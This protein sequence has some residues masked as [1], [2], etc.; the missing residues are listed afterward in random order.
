MRLLLLHLSDIH[1][2]SISDRVVKLSEKIASSIYPQIRQVDKCVILITGDITN[3]G[4][5]EEFEVAADFFLN[6]KQTLEKESGKEV[7]IISVPGNHDCLLKPEN[8]VRT[9]IIEGLTESDAKNSQIVDMCTS[10]QE[11]Y[12]AFRKR[13]TLINPVFEDK[14]WSEYEVLVNGQPIRFSAI[15]AS[16][17]SSIHEK[18]G[19]LIFPIDNYSNYL[20]EPSL[21][22]FVLLHHPLNWYAQTSI[23]PLKRTL[24]YSATAVLSGHEHHGSS[25]TIIDNNYGTSLFFEAPALQP[26]E[27]N[28]AVECG[29][30]SL[31]FDFVNQ[32]VIETAF[33]IS[34]YQTVECKTTRTVSIEQI[35]TV[36]TELED[37]TQE[38]QNVL[39]DPGADFKSNNETEATIDDFYV[40]PEIQAI[41]GNDNSYLIEDSESLISEDPHSKKILFIGES[42]SGKTSLIFQAFKRYRKLGLYPIY[43]NG[44]ELKNPTENEINKV[45]TKAQT[46]QYLNPSIFSSLPKDKMVVLVDNIDRIR[47]GLRALPKL[48]EFLDKHYCAILITATTGFEFGEL[49]DKQAQESTKNFITYSIR[50]LGKW[51]KHRLIRRWCICSKTFNTSSE[52]ESKIFAVEKTLNVV[53]GKNLVPGVP[54]YILILLQSIEK[55][56]ESALTNSH[57]GS[58]Y[59]YMIDRSL[60]DAGVV[61]AKIVEI[62][63]YLSAL[64]WLFNDGDIRE[65]SIVELRAFNKQYSEIQNSVDLES[66]LNLLCK[67]RMLVKRDDY[68]SFTYP[69][70][71]YYFLGKYIA[72]NINKI[73]ELKLKVSK[74]CEAL[75]KK[76]YANCILFI[77]HHINDEWIIN[78]VS[79]ELDKCFTGVPDICFNGDIDSINELVKITSTLIIDAP[80]VEKFREEELKHSDRKELANQ[81][82]KAVEDLE[83]NNIEISLLI[84]HINKSFITSRILGQILKGYHGDISR[85]NRE[86][87]INKIFSS[88]LRFLFHFIS[89]LMQDPTALVSTIESGLEP[90]EG[91]S[92]DERIKEIRQNIY[93]FIGILCTTTLQR[94]AENVSSDDLREDISEVAKNKGT[95]AYR[96]IEAAT[97]FIR[98]NSLPYDAILK[99]S[100]D[101]AQNPFAFRLL[102]SLAAFHIRS[103]PMKDSDRQKLCST[104]KIELLT[105]RPADILTE[106]IK[107][108]II[109]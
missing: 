8:S 107:P 21:A 53:L 43:L 61:P 59:G 19:S 2:S 46:E 29:F 16:W 13:T 31:D 23:H 9:R 102:Q 97:N 48:I 94:T 35:T 70:I 15:N 4:T 104:T 18:P 100:T 49:L 87:L 14:L 91:Q 47:S 64:A 30:L 56:Q 37:I 79:E 32:K 60:R 105:S 1:L 5:A 38:F 62:T 84:E 88:Q 77:A 17:M 11:N 52:L 98:P 22:R 44:A 41:S 10:A 76:D 12:F 106:T 80:N 68:Y 40:F 96:L 99:L 33:Q 51:L 7:E 71:Y 81:N 93:Q 69:Y 65:C 24:R 95:N 26:H 63:G 39:N 89:T 108:T 103:F 28:V 57:I 42:S 3:H 54:I 67:S 50:P 58:Y 34:N 20:K 6:I 78:R 75:H 92:K 86:N 101:T 82:K 90:V 36:L 74:W 25:G 66:R 72:K 73:P 85:E 55:N 45:I 83:Q 109:K 27:K